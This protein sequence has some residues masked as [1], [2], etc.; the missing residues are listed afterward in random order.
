MEL[1]LQNMWNANSTLKKLKKNEFRSNLQ[2]QTP[3]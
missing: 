3:L 1:T 2:R